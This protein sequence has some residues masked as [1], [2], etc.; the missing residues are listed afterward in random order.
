MTFLFDNDEYMVR[1]LEI[2]SDKDR[3]DMCS[4]RMELF[5][6]AA[7]SPDAAACVMPFPACFYDRVKKV[8]LLQELW[9]S[10]FTIPALSTLNEGTKLPQRTW[11]LLYWILTN[12]LTIQPVPASPDTIKSWSAETGLS[13]NIPLGGALLFKVLNPFP[14]KGFL[15]GKAQYGTVFGF[16]GSKVSN[17]HS[18]VHR[19][20]VSA[21]NTRSLFGVGSYLS[22][23]F[24][25]SINYSPLEVSWPK[26]S[27]GG[28][29]RC[30]GI[31]EVVKDPSIKKLVFRPAG[32]STAG[33][34]QQ[35]IIFYV[36]EKDELVQLSHLLLFRKGSK[37]LFP[38]STGEEKATSVS[39]PAPS[40]SEQLQVVP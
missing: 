18:I 23:S 32:G 24:R 8:K 40:E 4:L 22:S 14:K 21:L 7:L 33:N 10:I 29:F 34:Q 35:N 28:S 19:G 9:D 27:F 37:Y 6:A 16:H 1:V 12:P 39:S 15:E 3:V 36:V 13:L 17:F 26:G 25:Y 38:E 11:E 31:C 20:L 5:I 30:L 2:L